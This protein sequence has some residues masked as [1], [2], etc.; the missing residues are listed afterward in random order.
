MTTALPILYTRENGSE[1]L[2]MFED[3]PITEQPLAGFND[4]SLT[5]FPERQGLTL[6][7]ARK[8]VAMPDNSMPTI[9]G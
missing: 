5:I 7:V 8:G 3:S 9:E 6:C 1:S 2:H 4:Q